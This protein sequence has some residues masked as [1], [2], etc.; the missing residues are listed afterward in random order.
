MTFHN[1]D[2]EIMSS[3]SYLMVFHDIYPVLKETNLYKVLLFSINL[4]WYIW[5]IEVLKLVLKIEHL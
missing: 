3:A 2:L 4:L 5:Q 1:R